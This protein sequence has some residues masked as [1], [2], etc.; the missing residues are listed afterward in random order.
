[1]LHPVHLQVRD[2]VTRFRY[3]D[4]QHLEEALNRI[5]RV[6][7]A[8]GVPRR[9]S[10]LLTAIREEVV[11]G[12]YTLVGRV[13]WWTGGV[14]WGG[15]DAGAGG[16]WLGGRE[17]TPLGVD[18]L[19]ADTEPFCEVP[20]C[21]TSS[22]TPASPHPAPLHASFC[23]RTLTLRTLP[24]TQ[25]CPPPHF[26]PAGSGVSEQGGADPPAVGGAPG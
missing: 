3:G 17:Y 13:G 4:E 12:A 1:M 7:K 14:R 25:Q 15:G 8:G 9:L 19:Q 18:D 22:P 5:F 24:T 23:G 26:L 20:G 2:D 10:P 6:G 11:D 21:P 16:G